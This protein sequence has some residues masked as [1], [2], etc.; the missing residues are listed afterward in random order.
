M[1][2][3]HTAM[4]LA[5]FA[6]AAAAGSANAEF[7]VQGTAAQAAAPQGQ[8]SVRASSDNAGVA[9]RVSGVDGDPQG[10]V[11]FRSANPHRA[12]MGAGVHE[13]GQ[14]PQSPRAAKGFARSV[15]L[16]TALK[17]IVPAGWK[18]RKYGDIDLAAKVSWRGDDR[19][20]VDV[21]DELARAEGF[22]ATVN[23]DTQ[24]LTISPASQGA[25]RQTLDAA[26]NQAPQGALA[27]QSGAASRP[28]STIRE[29]IGA[30]Q[31]PAAGVVALAPAGVVG[32]PIQVAQAV[33]VAQV[34]QLSTD[35]TLK[36]NI[37]AWAKRAGWTVSWDPQMPDYPITVPMSF[38]GTL[39]GTGGPLYQIAVA[40][41]DAD[42]PFTI[43]L[44]RGNKTIRIEKVDYDQQPNQDFM[45]EHRASAD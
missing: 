38:S 16:L 18:A 27:T 21:L 32:R 5:A 19:S 30:A 3:K 24:E 36:Q 20:W 44:L 25:V 40:Y 15:P 6:L 45:P 2:R 34:W 41:K 17:Q 10:S 23:W 31:G 12:Q 22:A 11:E 9:T 42:Q 29:E 33:P 4:A 13:V 7:M 8:Q 43:R 28:A 26:S 1:M 14:S 37:E 39:E 35:K